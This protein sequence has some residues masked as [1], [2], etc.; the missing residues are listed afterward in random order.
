MKLQARNKEK[1]VKIKL[2]AREAN[3]RLLKD[4]GES[5]GE[6][7]QVLEVERPRKKRR[8]EVVELD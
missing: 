8:V 1:Q 7:K 2:E 5:D 6:G 4:A 3:L